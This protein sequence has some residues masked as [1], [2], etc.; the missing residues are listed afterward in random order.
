VSARSRQHQQAQRLA[1]PPS[2]S[3]S[4]GLPQ[5]EL[6]ALKVSALSA[7]ALAAGV[8]PSALEAANERPDRKVRT[9]AVHSA[10]LP[11]AGVIPRVCTRSSA[12]TLA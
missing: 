10:G 12:R 5:K 2:A 8:I 4:E 7:R 3:A 9:P 6:A 11:Q 1:Q